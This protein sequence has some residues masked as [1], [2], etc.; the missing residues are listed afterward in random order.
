M[1][2]T[3]T[4]LNKGFQ[5]VVVDCVCCEHRLSEREE[6]CPECQAPASLSQSVAMRGGEHR[7]VSVLVQATPEKRF[8]SACC[9][10]S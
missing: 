6:F 4:Q 3:P 1:I 7:F 10:T 9:S 5:P 8:I 2:T